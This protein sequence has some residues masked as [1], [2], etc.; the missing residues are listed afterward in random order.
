MEKRESAVYGY[1]IDNRMNN[2]IGVS[3][4]SV[5]ASFICAPM[6]SVWFLLLLLVP[7]VVFVYVKRSGCN[8]PLLIAG[9]YLILGERIIY[10]RA[11]TGVAL[12]KKHQILTLFADKGKS[13]VIA[14]D[15]FPTSARKD[16]KI[17]ANRTAK[18]NKVSE[19]IISRLRAY[20]P[21]IVIS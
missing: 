1:Q 20:S 10:Y 16:F 17:K 18:F 19:K 13:V 4:I 6:I 12:D 15:K 7:V 21:D 5:I 14:A 3:M 11:V 9:R 2:Y 8:K